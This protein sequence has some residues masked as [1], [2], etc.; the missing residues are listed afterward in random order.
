MD[1]YALAG[2]A[3]ALLALA[4]LAVSLLRARR[5]AARFRILDEVA[6]VSDSAIDLSETLDAICDILVPAVADFCTIDVISD[7]RGRARRR[8]G[9]SARGRRGGAGPRRA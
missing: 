8:P 2:A 4:L 6:R 7:G 9:R 5:E 1:W 3:V